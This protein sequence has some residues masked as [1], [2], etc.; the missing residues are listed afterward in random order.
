MKKSLIAIA[1]LAITMPAV[2]GDLKLH[3]WP[4]TGQ[5]DPVTPEYI[6]Q[7][8]ATIDVILDVGYYIHITNQDD[9]EV[10]QDDVNNA[11][12]NP[13]QSYF[14]CNDT[15]VVSNF[16][17]DITLAAAA[18]SAACGTWVAKWADDDAGTNPQD[19][20][21]TPA[22][23]STISTFIC[24]TGTGVNI[25]ALPGGATDVPVAQVTVTVVP[26]GTP[27]G[28]WVWTP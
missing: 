17:A 28:S 27:S 22:V 19:V 4:I 12:I 10:E 18:T 7:V 14:G 13:T 6:G 16:A 8:V 15:D 2:A 25:G 21:T 11:V 5:P 3:D 26:V 9:I 23:A 24:V 20:L 1:I